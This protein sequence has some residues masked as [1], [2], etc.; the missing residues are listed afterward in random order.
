MVTLIDTSKYRR[1]TGH[2]Y[3][4]AVNWLLIIQVSQKLW[5]Q[6]KVI[7]LIKTCKHIGQSKFR[8]GLCYFISF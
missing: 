8:M 7:G 6:P 3:L 4:R 5:P 2:C 1:H